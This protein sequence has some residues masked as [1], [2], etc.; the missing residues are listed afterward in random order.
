MRITWLAIVLAACEAGAPTPP[1]ISPPPTTTPPPAPPADAPVSHEPPSPR[2]VRDAVFPAADVAP[3]ARKSYKTAVLLIAPSPNPWEQIDEPMLD[4]ARFV[5][6][7]CAIDGVL[8]T[9]ERCGDIMPARTTIRIPTGELAVSRSTKK[10]HDNAGEHDYPA[11]YGPE[12]CMYNTCIGQT[13]PYMPAHKRDLAQHTTLGVWPADADIALEVAGGGIVG[14]AP[15]AAADEVVTQAFARG[16][17]HYAAIRT[18]G[19]GVAAWDAGAGW[20]RARVD[21]GQGFA[22]L[23]TTD[24]GHDGHLELIAYQLWAN[25]YGISVFRDT[26]TKPAYEFSCGNI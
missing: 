5:P 15:A 18:N 12:C 19:S 25:D 6:L 8:A 7:V 13:I 17:H 23:A 16:A 26:D 14:N 20:L 4:G 11:P 1:A 10:F 21:F 9:G 3:G 22:L 2:A 24:L